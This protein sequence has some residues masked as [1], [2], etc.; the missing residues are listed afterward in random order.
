MLAGGDAAIVLGVA[1]IAAYKRANCCGCP[2]SRD[3]RCASPPRL[4]S[5]RRRADWRRCRGVATD[6]WQSARGAART[7]QTADLVVV[8]PA[9][10]DILARA[11]HGL[12]DLPT[13]T[14]SRRVVRCCS[15][16]P[17]TRKCGEHPATSQ[18]GHPAPARCHRDEPASA[19]SSARTRARSP[20]EPGEIFAVAIRVAPRRDPADLV[21]RRVVVTAGG[22][23]PLDP[24]RFRGTDP[25]A[26]RGTRWP[27]RR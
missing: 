4:R 1:R 18:R 10:A 22:R 20:P 15:P 16:R 7:G 12:D 13:S 6:V 17:C 25:P 8:A 2:S 23:E 9:T 14:C 26:G 27:G 19:D 3:T 24:V 21:G 11:A 5:L